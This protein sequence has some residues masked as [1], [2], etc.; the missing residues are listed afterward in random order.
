MVYSNSII[1]SLRL[2][3]Y[4]LIKEQ[5]CV[6]FVSFFALQVNNVSVVHHFSLVMQL[7]LIIRSRHAL[8]FYIGD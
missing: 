6:P 5:L 8:D 2:F 4:T 7:V 3:Y 1:S